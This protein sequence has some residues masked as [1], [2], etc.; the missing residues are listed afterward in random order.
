MGL[1]SELEHAEITLR[2]GEEVRGEIAATYR[3]VLGAEPEVV[4]ILLGYLATGF[5]L[6]T[7]IA[8]PYSDRIDAGTYVGFLIFS[9]ILWPLLALFDRLHSVDCLRRDWR[10]R[11]SLH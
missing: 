10:A 9:L 8:L 2:E 7:V 11:V 3:K 6:A 1:E 5:T 4:G